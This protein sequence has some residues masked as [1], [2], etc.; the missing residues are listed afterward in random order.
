MRGEW[1]M[2]KTEEYLPA[3]RKISGK[4]MKRKKKQEV[5]PLG[6]ELSN[7]KGEMKIEYDGI[8]CDYN[9][10]QLNIMED[11]IEMG[12]MKS[13]FVYI[14]YGKFIVITIYLMYNIY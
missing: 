5:L 1:I 12:Q 7:E 14:N 4:K 11:I 3:R 9:G 13:I 10:Y 8:K 6:I 2:E